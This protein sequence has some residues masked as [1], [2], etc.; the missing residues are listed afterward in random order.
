MYGVSVDVRTDIH[1][2]ASFA[3]V[4]KYVLDKHPNRTFERTELQRNGLPGVEL[5]VSIDGRKR[6][7]FQTFLDIPNGRSITIIFSANRAWDE[8]LAR[9]F[10]NSLDIQL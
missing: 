9:A 4:E 10:I 3:N 7:L 6:Q 8:V 1:D 5:V 2:T